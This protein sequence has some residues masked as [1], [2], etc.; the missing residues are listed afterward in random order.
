M[1]SILNE[2]RMIRSCEELDINLQNSNRYCLIINEKSGEKS[3]YCFNTP[4]YELMN[5]RLIKPKFE[6]FSEGYIHHGTN[7]YIKLIKNQIYMSSVHGNATIILDNR[8]FVLNKDGELIGDNLK[9]IPVINGIKINASNNSK[10]KFK[11]IKDNF[12]Y[13]KRTNRKYFA[14]MIDKAKPLLSISGLYSFNQNPNEVKPVYIDFDESDNEYIF[15]ISS[16]GSNELNFEINMYEE[17][18]IY[19]T[20]V[21]SEHPDENNAYGSVAFIGRTKNFGDQW[22]YARPDFEKISELC[23]HQILNV[24]LYIPQYNN[25]DGG[26]LIYIPERRF[27][28][29]GS[30][31][32][33]KIPIYEKV[34]KTN[35]IGKYQVADI[36]KAA[37]DNESN[38][39][40]NKTGIV[41]RSESKV[42]AIA[43]ADNYCTPQIM[44]IKYL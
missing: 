2:I 25:E 29:F 26:M 20:T 33:N 1:I 13:E 40:L 5:K 14:F 23:H 12:A 32:N 38:K 4:I 10:I 37:V 18:L 16:D 35:R 6:K 9:V 42:Y 44:E 22:L 11:L 41:L 43:T 8:D 36:T 27:C 7:S 39:L 34:G 15:Y 31:W 28:S 21:E 30:T 3:A 17:K 19:D 24:N